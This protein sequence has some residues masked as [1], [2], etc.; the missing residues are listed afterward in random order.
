MLAVN[1]PL[2]AVPTLVINI[3]A[4]RLGR[5]GSSAADLVCRVAGVTGIAFLVAALIALV[6]LFTQIWVMNPNTWSVGIY[7]V[8]SWG[9]L[10]CS[11]IALVA[12]R[13]EILPWAAVLATSTA[14]FVT[15]YLIWQTRLFSRQVDVGSDV[16]EYGIVAGLLGIVFAAFLPRSR[17]TLRVVVYVCTLAA[18]SIIVG[19]HTSRMA[20]SINEADTCEPVFEYFLK[21]DH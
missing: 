17:R 1:L 7:V 8:A 10:F 2:L 11:L 6:D 9:T 21:R 16:L 20:C 12:K 13:S 3:Y 18:V 19:L 5:R 15:T 4:F 14:A